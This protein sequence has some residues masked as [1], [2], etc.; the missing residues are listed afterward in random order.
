LLSLLPL[1]DGHFE[2]LVTDC[3]ARV[4]DI[5]NRYR[6]CQIVGIEKLQKPYPI[7]KAAIS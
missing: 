7:A 3:F 4:V 1:P 2:E 6:M 5:S